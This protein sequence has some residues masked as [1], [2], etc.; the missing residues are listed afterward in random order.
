MGLAL[1]QEIC[2]EHNAKLALDRN[3]G[4]GARFTLSLPC[5]PSHLMSRLDEPHGS[6][7]ETEAAS[8]R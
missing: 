1:A 4:P 8:P 6:R 7:T 5:F 3:Y 2:T